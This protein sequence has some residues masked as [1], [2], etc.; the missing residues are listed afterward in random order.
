MDS[1]ARLAG[2]QP[3]HQLSTKG[4]NCLTLLQPVW[5]LN[6]TGNHLVAARNRA[7][8]VRHQPTALVTTRIR[9]KGRGDIG[10]SF[11]TVAVARNPERRLD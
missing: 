1:E 5:A 6:L 8:G 2:H 9:G 10:E 7:F 11:R 3:D 4:R